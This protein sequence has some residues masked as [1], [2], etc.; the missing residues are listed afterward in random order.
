VHDWAW[1]HGDLAIDE[2]TIDLTKVT[3]R[4]ATEAPAFT[5]QRIAMRA[6]T[7]RFSLSEPSLHGVDYHLVVED[8]ATDDARRLGALLAIP[9]ESGKAHA[10]ADI[11]VA[12]GTA[13]GGVKL[14]GEGAG[15]RFDDTHVAGDFDVDVVVK[16]L[17]PGEDARVDLSGSRITLRDVKASGAKARSTAW[18]GEVTL[19]SG[20]L[21]L[22][23]SPAFD[24]FVQVR[25]DDANPILAIALENS[26]PKFL[27]AML[28]APDLSGQARITLQADRKAILDAHVRGG[29]VVLVGDYVRRPGHV[30]GALTVAKGGVSAGVKLDDEGTYVRLF[31]LAKWR[32]EEKKAV[33]D[34]FRGSDHAHAEE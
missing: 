15:V 5:V 27:I 33:V 3:A 26:L 19:L 28:K 12:R 6:R 18:K 7:D 10:S 8:A 16:G 21:R 9:I 24:A 2:A 30:R 22:T 32:E 13:T 25:A 23:G 31:R 11:T 4:R 1:E 29:D 14:V 34:L 20:A 17:L